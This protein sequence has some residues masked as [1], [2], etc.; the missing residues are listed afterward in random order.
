MQNISN[1]HLTLR[2]IQSKTTMRCLPTTIRKAVFSKSTHNSKDT[3]QD[4]RTH[5][6]GDALEN[7]LWTL[8]QL[9]M[10]SASGPGTPLLSSFLGVWGGISIQLHHTDIHRSSMNTDWNLGIAQMY[11]SIE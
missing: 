11:I 6:A 4:S 1:H 2:E 8:I 10:C 3:E 5:A 9:S 7:T